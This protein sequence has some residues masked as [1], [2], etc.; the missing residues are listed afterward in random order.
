MFDPS[1]RLKVGTLAMS[2][3]EKAQ[4]RKIR[5]RIEVRAERD[6]TYEER[7][8]E[9]LAFGKKVLYITCPLC[10][11]NRVLNPHEKDQTRFEV[12]PD[13][14]LIQ[15]RYGGGRG[16][17]FFLN[18]DESLSLEEVKEQYPDLY[19]NIKRELARLIAIFK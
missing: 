2:K 15:A 5:R 10:G 4:E 11:R 18:K 17:G 3:K 14:L 13:F 19:E 12:K 1:R 7:K 16:S 8:E 6:L 9:A